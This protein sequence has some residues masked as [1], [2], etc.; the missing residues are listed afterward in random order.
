MKS[1]QIYSKESYHL[2]RAI[3]I[4]VGII[5]PALI[6][7]NLSGLGGQVL[8]WTTLGLSVASALCVAALE[9]VRWGERWRINRSFLPLLFREGV[10]FSTLSGRYKRYSDHDAGYQL[11]VTS[12]EALLELYEAEYQHQLI[13]PTLASKERSADAKIASVD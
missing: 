4:G 11:F 10:Q 7:L 12:V 3:S 13:A 1:R 5:V 9:L 8:Q 6:S 2:L